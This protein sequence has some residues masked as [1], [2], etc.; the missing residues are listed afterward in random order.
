[1]SVAELQSSASRS[2]QNIRVVAI[3]DTDLEFLK[4]LKLAEEFKFPG[5]PDVVGAV[6]L[7]D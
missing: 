1:M 5:L 2:A 6:H 4:M 3:T 7:F